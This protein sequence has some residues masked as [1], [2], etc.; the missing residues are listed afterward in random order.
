MLELN[1]SILVLLEFLVERILHAVNDL[2]G[3]VDLVGGET[4]VSY[5]PVYPDVPDVLHS[6]AVQS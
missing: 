6:N 3:D 2:P 4:S 5:D 1:T